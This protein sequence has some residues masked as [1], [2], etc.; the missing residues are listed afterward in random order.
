MINE[1]GERHASPAPVEHPPHMLDAPRS[2]AQKKLF[3]KTKREEAKAD[4][5]KP[6]AKKSAKE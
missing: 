4:E 6:A 2:R 1:K 5:K 3:A